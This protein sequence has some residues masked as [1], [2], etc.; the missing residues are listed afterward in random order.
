MTLVFVM[1]AAVATAAGVLAAHSQSPKALL[2]AMQHAAR[3]RHSVH[4]VSADS[5]STYKARAIFDVGPKKGI[6]RVTVTEYGR[7][8]PAEVRVTGNV[9]YL[10][11]TVFTLDVFFGF[12]PAQAKKYAGVWISIPR[13]NPAFKVIAGGVTFESFTADLFPVAPLYP[14]KSGQVIGVRGA[15]PG[16]GS[17]E[18]KTVLAPNHGEPLPAKAITGFVDRQGTDTWSMSHWNEAFGVSAPAHA[19]PISKVTGG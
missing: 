17:Q 19:V 14:V 5:E 10:K 13:A 8:G 18:T 15:G 1:A 11:G 6:E 4:Y 12:S 2:A 3:S 16:S 9:A 7:T